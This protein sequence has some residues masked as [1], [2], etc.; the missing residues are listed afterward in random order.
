MQTRSSLIKIL[1]SLAY[2]LVGLAG[3]RVTAETTPVQG[4]PRRDRTVLRKPWSNEPVSV[5]SVKNKKKNIEVGRAFDDDEDWLDG[6]AVTVANNSDKTVTAITVEIVFP[7]EAGDTRPP[8]AEDLHFGP[9]PIFPNM[10][11]EIEIR[12]LG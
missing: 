7:R 1:W 12:S 9:S 4:P 3:L 5:V 11:T 2:V 10:Q 6:F 8:V